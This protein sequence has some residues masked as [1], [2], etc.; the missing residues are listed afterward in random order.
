MNEIY[1]LLNNE[2]KRNACTAIQ[3]ANQDMVC[4][5]K[6]KTRNSEQN[7]KFHAMCQDLAG[8]KWGGK[9]RS[10]AE[11]KVLLVSGHMIATGEAQ[12][13]TVGLEGEVVNLRESTAAMGVKRMASLI[14]YTQAWIANNLEE[15]K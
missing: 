9:E 5:I 8:K 7:A 13:M 1:F 3:N 2:I 15:V 11:W 12:N 10:A 6:P 4:T 14:E